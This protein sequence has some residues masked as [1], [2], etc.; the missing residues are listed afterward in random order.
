ME[1]RLRG[2]NTKQ[3]ASLFFFLSFSL[4]LSL[5]L[6]RYQ[7]FLFTGM[8]SRGRR[9]M[10]L[11]RLV[12]GIYAIGDSDK[13]RKGERE[14]ERER[15]GGREGS[16][17]CPGPQPYLCRFL[18]LPTGWAGEGRREAGG[19][20]LLFL[21]QATLNLPTFYDRLT[22]SSVHQ[23]SERCCRARPGLLLLLLPPFFLPN[24]QSAG[25]CRSFPVG[26]HGF[27]FVSR[28][29]LT[30]IWKLSRDNR[31]DGA[32]GGKNFAEIFRR[33]FFFSS[34]TPLLLRSLER[35]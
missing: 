9:V 13:P 19:G 8:G 5:F 3:P 35:V 33:I 25:G 16:E 21:H 27:S 20:T 11:F 26:S 31:E 18:C 6:S 12:L 32:G 1:P 2:R 14:R 15:E 23:L 7:A 10:I 28:G 4:S 34:P 29:S 30:A 22:A 17:I 24:L